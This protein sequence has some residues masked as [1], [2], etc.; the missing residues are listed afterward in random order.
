MLWDTT[1]PAKVAQIKAHICAGAV[2]NP[3]IYESP[4]AEHF[5]DIWGVSADQT[6]RE[7]YYL[8]RCAFGELQ[9]AGLVLEGSGGSVRQSR[10]E[11]WAELGFAK[12]HGAHWEATPRLLL[13]GA[14][15]WSGTPA[16]RW[17][18]V[19][20]LYEEARV[21]RSGGHEVAAAVTL[22]AATE[23][24]VRC[25]FA[26]LP[27]ITEPDSRLAN[28]IVKLFERLPRAQFQSASAGAGTD[29]SGARATI[30]N[31]RTAGNEAAH[32]GRVVDPVRLELVLATLPSALPWLSLA[33][34]PQP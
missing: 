12:A 20:D 4:V 9:A 2:A 6:R 26:D 28:R 11:F 29:L 8:M 22:R 19:N 16:T 15:A 24:A 34:D 18:N 3:L 1:W 30:E 27:G 21:V 31:A 10:D 17:P 7:V 32:E 23:D 14:S 13:G 33:T 5:I 25:A